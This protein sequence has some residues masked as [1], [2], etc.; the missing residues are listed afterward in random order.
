MGDSKSLKTEHPL[1]W[2]KTSKGGIQE[3]DLNQI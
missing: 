3:F 2:I 1:S